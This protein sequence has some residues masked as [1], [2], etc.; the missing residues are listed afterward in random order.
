MNELN[1]E[2]VQWI[3]L[4]DK[5]KEY[6]KKIRELKELKDSKFD[7]IYDKLDVDNKNIED[8][9]KY[10]IDQFNSMI[11]FNK[12]VSYNPLTYRYL[13][14]CLN[15]YLKDENETKKIIEYIKNNRNKDSKTILKRD[16][17]I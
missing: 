7:S 9:P 4:D 13:E 5:I 3:K 2:I 14:N 10:K 12:L 6:N 11:S 15:E 1:M 16:N 17:I 8:L